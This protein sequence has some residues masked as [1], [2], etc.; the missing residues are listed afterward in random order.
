MHLQQTMATQA[1]N[2]DMESCLEG[3]VDSSILGICLLESLQKTTS[4]Y[5]DKIALVC[6]DAKLTF[7][8]LSSLSNRLS[9]VLAAE[10]INHG[11][12]VGVSLERSLSFVTTVLALWK[13]GAAYVPID[14]TFPAKRIE[15]TLDDARPKFLIDSG[16]THKPFAAR[17]G[18]FCLDI[19]EALRLAS[20]ATFSTRSG[21]QAS[22]HHN[23]LAY[24]IYTSGSTGRPKGVEVSH[25]SLSNLLL[26]M[27]TQPGCD[28]TDRVLAVI[29]FTFDMA[30]PELFLPLLC[31]ATVVIAQR[32]E[33]K[34]PSAI[35]DLV[36]CHQITMMQGTPTL[37]QM[38]LDAGWTKGP[39]L[40]RILC[41]GE[42]M[43]KTLMIRLLHHTDEL[44]NVYGPTEATV[45]A[46]VW[47][48]E[49]GQDVLIGTPVK[50]N[51][52][53]VVNENLSPVELGSVGELCIGGAGVARGYRGNSE[54]TTA[55][56]RQ[57]PF[58]PGLLYRTGDLARF[59][60]PGGVAVLGRS[61]TQV[62]IRGHRI[63]TGDIEAAIIAC[64]EIS[65]V[66]V[67][68]RDDRL[69]AYCVRR[70]RQLNGTANQT[71]K[72]MA[73]DRILQPWLADRLPPY[74]LPA[75]YIELQQFPVTSSGKIDRKALPDPLSKRQT[76]TVK[77]QHHPT[78]EL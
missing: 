14:P 59:L 53:Y 51:Y 63:E 15:Q 44:W 9:S 72:D 58:H 20:K 24:V 38:L 7:G 40:K 2:G 42:A 22:I 4:S 39:R 67:I 75:F 34:D 33:V 45:Y 78:T 31:G 61:D 23:D 6:G 56:F 74:M 65:G 36:E 18:F 54:L 50:N 69:L 27:Q 52:L 25:G 5:K 3:D 37:W 46:S 21:P 8:E 28:E 71:T 11:D 19:D 41:G 68:G 35:L 57:N 29:T 55:H 12:L 10:G 43:N 47:R 17:D 32:H 76:S 13:L 77:P 49:K 62:K 48:A 26:S 30:I 60:A 1:S 16:N 70:S 64:A 66:V 73:L